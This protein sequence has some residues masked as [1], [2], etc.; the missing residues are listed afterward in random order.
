MLN[1]NK[2]DNSRNLWKQDE[3]FDTISNDKINKFFENYKQFDEFLLSKSDKVLEFSGRLFL[4]SEVSEKFHSDFY[5]TFLNSIKNL[6][7][8]EEIFRR[9]W[10]AYYNKKDYVL[11]TR[12]KMYDS[13]PFV[14]DEFSSILLWDVT[15]AHIIERRTDFNN[16]EFHYIVY[17]ERI[18]KFVQELL[19]R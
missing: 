9:L 6:V 10:L 11:S 2:N 4:D 14:D 15:I 5:E 16:V 12:K 1:D 3:I 17:P 8:D 19:K 13:D 7:W 18:L